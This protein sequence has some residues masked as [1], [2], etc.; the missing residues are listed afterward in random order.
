MKSF[1]QKIVD[2]V[3]AFGRMYAWLVR[4]KT[5]EQI[6]A[7]IA[8]RHNELTPDQWHRW[9]Q[10]NRKRQRQLTALKRLGHPLN[11]KVTSIPRWVVK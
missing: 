5:T 4:H 7:Y 1:D 10:A 2:R 3:Q 8:R 9:Y 6:F 11:P